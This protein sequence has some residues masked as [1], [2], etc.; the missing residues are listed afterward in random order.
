MIGFQ[1]DLQGDNPGPNEGIETRSLGKNE[2][3]E[4]VSSTYMIP[5]Y[6][7]RGMTREYLLQVKNEQV[8]R[9]PTMEYRHFEINLS[10]SHQKKVGITNNALLVR[11]LNILLSDKGR[12]PLGF[13]EYDV[14]EQNWLH[15]VAR[16]IDQTNVLEFFESAVAPEPPLTRNSSDISKTYFGRLHAGQWLFRLQNARN[17]KKLWENLKILSE[18]YR[19]YASYKINLDLLDHELQLTRDKVVT[20]EGTLT[21]LVNKAAFEYTSNENPLIKPEVV[22]MGGDAYTQEMKNTLSTN[23]KVYSIIMKY[24]LCLLY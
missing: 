12:Q 20:L 11:K 15:K 22:I 5:P 24:L 18:T 7:S 19:S 14:P 16:Y 6:C 17:N 10:K 21:N 2:L 9:V 1:P 23:A 13:T 3:Y 8:F 4:L